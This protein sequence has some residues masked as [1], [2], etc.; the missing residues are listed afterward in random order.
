MQPD[1]VGR[2]VDQSMIECLDMQL[3]GFA[4]F[5]EAKVLE[6]HMTAHREVRAVNLEDEARGANGLVLGSHRLSEGAQISFVRW[7]MLVGQEKSYN[8]RGS[9]A[10][11]GFD[12]MGR[13][14]CRLQVLHV[15][16]NRISI[17]V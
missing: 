14:H 8:P 6:L 9:C 7:I 13:G 5:S 16:P 17:S 2:Y 12:R 3:N 10:H 11:E 1:T 4:K 15:D